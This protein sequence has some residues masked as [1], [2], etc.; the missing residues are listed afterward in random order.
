MPAPLSRMLNPVYSGVCSAVTKM[1]PPGGVCSMQFFRIFS[2][3]SVV[4]PASPVKT[5]SVSPPIRSTCS[6]SSIGIANGSIAAR[7]TLSSVTGCCSNCTVPASILD[8]FSSATIN[9]SIRASSVCSSR[10]SSPR[11]CGVRSGCCK[12]DTTILVEVSGVRSWC[13]ISASASA[14]YCLSRCNRSAC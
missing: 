11:R 14:R 13:E 1:C 5:A 6:R 2:T 4:Q 9:Q 3:A 10:S 8:I 12:K 7:I